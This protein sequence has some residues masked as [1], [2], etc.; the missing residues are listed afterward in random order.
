MPLTQVD[1]VNM[2]LALARTL[3]VT[4]ETTLLEARRLR[5]AITNRT[6]KDQITV[7]IEKARTLASAVAARIAVLDP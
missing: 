5:D 7:E 3:I 4:S 1:Q 2:Q 6:E